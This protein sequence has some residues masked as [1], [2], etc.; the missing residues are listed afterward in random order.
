[1]WGG[2]CMFV[3]FGWCVVCYCLAAMGTAFSVGCVTAVSLV[4]YRFRVLVFG[5]TSLFCCFV[6]VGLL[7]VLIG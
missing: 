4:A 6:P 7:S 5:R 1:M 2:F 3:C